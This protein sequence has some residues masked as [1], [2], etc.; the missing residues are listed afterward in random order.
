MGTYREGCWPCFQPCNARGAFLRLAPSRATVA[1]VLRK[2][3]TKGGC[4]HTIEGDPEMA[5]L[6]RQH[7]RLSPFADRIH[8]HV[9]EARNLLITLPELTEPF[10]LV[11]LDGDK[12]GYPEH[13]FWCME[14]L[15]IGGLLIADNVLWDGKVG[16]KK[17]DRDTKALKEY[18]RLVFEDERLSSVVLPLR[19]GLSVARRTQ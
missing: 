15:S 17:P 3:W 8:L 7:F 1:C 6:A 19:D 5:H 2:G 10:D 18:N 12:R 14:H 16:T 4:L 11:Y 13:F 9:G